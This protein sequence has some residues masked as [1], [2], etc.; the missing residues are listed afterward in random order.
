MLINWF[1]DLNTVFYSSKLCSNVATWISLYA[2][3]LYINT[4]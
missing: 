3:A 1:T 2:R 4:F